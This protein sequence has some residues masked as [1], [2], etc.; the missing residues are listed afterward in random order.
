MQADT[1]PGSLFPG[2]AVVRL[3]SAGPVWAGQRPR[4]YSLLSLPLKFL[5]PQRHYNAFNALQPRK[6]RIRVGALGTCLTHGLFPQGQRIAAHRIQ[7]AAEE[8]QIRPY[9]PCLHIQSAESYRLAACGAWRRIP[10][11][12]IQLPASFTG[13]PIR[14]RM[15]FGPPL[16]FFWSSISPM[17]TT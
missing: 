6:Y 8:I 4:H 16:Q 7:I 3:W 5:A 11:V 15:P 2:G 13:E 14:V 1:L 17:R 10:V 12:L 9:I